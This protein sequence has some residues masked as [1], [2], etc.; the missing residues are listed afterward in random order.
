MRHSRSSWRIK[1]IVLVKVE[2]HIGEG[3]VIAVDATSAV[4]PLPSGASLPLR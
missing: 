2:G 4:A 1:D 3:P